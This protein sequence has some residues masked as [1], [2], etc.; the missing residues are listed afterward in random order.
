MS[1]VMVGEWFF[2][3]IFVE[4]VVDGIKGFDGWK[5]VGLVCDEFSSDRGS[6]EL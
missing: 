6:S 5:E 1:F 3:K 2:E 4:D